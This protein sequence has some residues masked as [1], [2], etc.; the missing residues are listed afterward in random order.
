MIRDI[1]KERKVSPESHKGD[2]LDQ[3]VDDIKKEKFLSDD[4]IVLVMFGILLA[5]FETISATLT[6]A[7]KLLI[8]NPSVMQELIVSDNYLT[9]FQSFYYHA[10]IDNPIGLE[11]LI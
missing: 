1:L 3:I 8:E 6:L 7:V 2:F 4:F 9:T 5:S 11:P 10:F